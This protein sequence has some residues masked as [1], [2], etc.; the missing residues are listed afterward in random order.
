MTTPSAT[1]LIVT[2]KYSLTSLTSSSFALPQLGC[3]QS[4]LSKSQGHLSLIF[5]SMFFVPSFVPSPLTDLATI[6]FKKI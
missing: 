6:N 3:V 5:S 2:G 4:S 1:M